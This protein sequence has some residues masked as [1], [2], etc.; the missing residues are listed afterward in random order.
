MD[1]KFKKV[2][3][4]KPWKLTDNEIIICGL[5]KK[6][7][8]PL[9]DI[10]SPLGYTYGK[11]TKYDVGT[12]QEQYIHLWYPEGD[13]CGTRLMFRPEEK[14]QAM[15]AKDYIIKNSGM[16][17][18][19]KKYSYS[20]FYDFSRSRAKLAGYDFYAGAHEEIKNKDASVVG[21]AVAGGVIAGPVGAVV[22]AISAVDKNIKK[23][24]SKNE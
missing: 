22:G 5:F 18:K 6:K 20:N 24:N 9:K 16:S 3:S 13:S 7:I 12:S 14:E 11:A 19:D 8:I 17:E 21:R 15:I 10:K 1:L 4:N 23:N 2:F